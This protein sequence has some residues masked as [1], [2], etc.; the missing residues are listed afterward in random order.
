SL[1]TEAARAALARSIVIS[2]PAGFHAGPG[3]RARLGMSPALFSLSRANHAG[4][5]R[6]L[7]PI[8]LQCATA[9][10]VDVA[11][12]IDLLTHLEAITRNVIVGGGARVSPEVR[13]IC[14]KANIVAADLVVRNVA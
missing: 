4:E 12:V 9:I 10:R 3:V 1:P 14:S 7:M 11:D 2:T 13:V 5:T 6:A 8:L